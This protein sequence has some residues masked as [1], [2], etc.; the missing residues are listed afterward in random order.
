MRICREFQRTYGAIIGEE[1]VQCRT[2]AAVAD[3]LFRRDGGV[4]GIP[5]VA[6]Y[7]FEQGTGEKVRA[8]N[9]DR[10]VSAGNE[11]C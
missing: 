5:E 8:I 3:H 4:E 11:L 2:A 10:A 7:L 6:A 9:G 1:F